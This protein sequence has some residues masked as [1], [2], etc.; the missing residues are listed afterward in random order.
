MLVIISYMGETPFV[1][2][3]PV[4]GA[5]PVYS[6]PTDVKKVNLKADG[7]AQ[8]GGTTLQII[9][10]VLS[11]NKS[12]LPFFLAFQGLQAVSNLDSAGVKEYYY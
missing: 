9:H 11:V 10:G 4:P 1:D 6:L 8:T 2:G 5:M 7:A 3:F 12:H